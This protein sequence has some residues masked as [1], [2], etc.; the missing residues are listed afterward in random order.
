MEESYL[1]LAVP[2]YLF[3]TQKVDS[4]IQSA[5]VWQLFVVLDTEIFKLL[6]SP[7]WQ[8]SLSLFITRSFS[9]ITEFMLRK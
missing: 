7:E 4:I 8:K 3:K 5:Y 6:K 9:R 2:R 1:G